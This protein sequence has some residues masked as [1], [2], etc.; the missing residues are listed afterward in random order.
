VYTCIPQTTYTIQQNRH[1]VLPGVTRASIL[2][3]AENW[4]DIDVIEADIA[5]QDIALAA[6]QGN[7]LE[8]FGAGTAAVIAPVNSIKYS[9]AASGTVKTITVPTGSDIGPVAKRLW[10]A[11][12]DI[13]TGAVEHEWSVKLDV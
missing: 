12:T 2:E 9:D 3:L 1:D 6:E 5:L 11:I 8:V 13:Q 4:A 10:T 7:L